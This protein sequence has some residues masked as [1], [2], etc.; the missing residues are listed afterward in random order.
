[1]PNNTL[2][3]DENTGD[4]VGWLADAINHADEVS[5][6]NVGTVCGADH[7]QLAFWLRELA[8]LERERDERD[9]KLSTIKDLLDEGMHEDQCGYNMQAVMQAHRVASGGPAPQ[10]TAHDPTCEA[11]TRRIRDIE[12]ERDE[13]RAACQMYAERG[14][15]FAAQ[16]DEKAVKIR[17][18]EAELAQARERIAHLTDAALWIAARLTARI[19]PRVMSR[20]DLEKH[21]QA[22]LEWALFETAPT[23]G[24][25][26]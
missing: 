12:R 19:D 8:R 11:M 22:T 26:E 20:A 4:P 23:G 18:M 9:A 3:Y 25:G 10:R 6:D 15:R 7:A 13:E 1:M 24:E 14:Q 16:A 2:Y 17:S 21:A 5:F